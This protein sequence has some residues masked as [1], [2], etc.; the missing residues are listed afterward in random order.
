MS[1]DPSQYDYIDSLGKRYDQMGNPNMI[2]FWEEQR[3]Q[4]FSQIKRHLGKADFTVIDLTDF[5]KNIQ[6]E[7]GEYIST[8]SEDQFSKIIQIGF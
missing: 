1:L 4:F 2:P 7:V 6:E 8:L 3:S 5:P